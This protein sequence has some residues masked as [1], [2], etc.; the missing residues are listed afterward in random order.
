[1]CFSP[2][3]PLGLCY[4]G[5]VVAVLEGSSFFF[6]RKESI[7]VFLPH[8]CGCRLL[9]VFFSLGLFFLGVVNNGG[10]AF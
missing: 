10:G 5:F 4:F 1:M 9:F 3:P 6:F 2:P 8:F 7:A